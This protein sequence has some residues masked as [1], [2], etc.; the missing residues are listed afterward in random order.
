MSQIHQLVHLPRGG[1]IAAKI[2]VFCGKRFNRAVDNLLRNLGSCRIVEVDPW[3]SRVLQGQGRELLANTC[4]VEGCG[5][6]KTFRENNLK[7]SPL[8]AIS[9]CFNRRF[10]ACECRVM[11]A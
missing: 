6:A 7:A 5:H 4:D 8:A 1:E 11:T 10:P 3:G 9:A 2:G